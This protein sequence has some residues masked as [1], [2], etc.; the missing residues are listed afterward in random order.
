MKP[1]P[2]TPPLDPCRKS[3]HECT[4]VAGG[5]QAEAGKI[6]ACAQSH[7]RNRLGVRRALATGV[8]RLRRGRWIDDR[9]TDGHSDRYLNES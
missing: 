8:I 5:T 6:R 9:E 4:F 2:K 3:D 7:R 1:A